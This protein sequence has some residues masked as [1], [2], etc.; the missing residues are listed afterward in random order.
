MRKS[1]EIP[2][3][4]SFISLTAPLIGD[5]YTAALI[6]EARGFAIAPVGA[7]GISP[8]FAFIIIWLCQAAVA[9]RPSALGGRKPA[10]LMVYYLETDG[11]ANFQSPSGPACFAQRDRGRAQRRFPDSYCGATG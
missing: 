7:F 4:R 10:L 1:R 9:G 5:E 8:F 6:H 3:L 11:G 2:E